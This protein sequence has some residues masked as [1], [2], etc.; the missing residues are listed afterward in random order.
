MLE[1]N[2]LTANDPLKKDVFM[3][4]YLKIGGKSGFRITNANA[5]L[6]Y[7]LIIVNVNPL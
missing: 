4:A 3:M 5:I 2:L 7:T 1:T 6:V